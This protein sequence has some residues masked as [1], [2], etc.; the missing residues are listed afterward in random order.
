[1]FAA[2]GFQLLSHIYTLFKVLP[3]H[4]SYKKE[5]LYYAAIHSFARHT[6]QPRYFRLRPQQD[7]NED[8]L[9]NAIRKH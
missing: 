1:M 7:L 8:T 6:P 2:V 4:F 9:V 5:C 3:I